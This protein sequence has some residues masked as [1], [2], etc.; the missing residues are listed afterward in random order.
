MPRKIRKCYY[1]KCKHGGQINIETDEYVQD[2]NLYH[3]DCYQEMKNLQLIRNLWIE[4]ISNTVSYSQLNKVLNSYLDRG[5]SSD[6]LL[7][8]LQYVIANHMT[9]RYPGGLQYY[10]DREEIKKQY[11]K[12]L[13]Q[14]LKQAPYNTAVQ[15][16][17]PKFAVKT[18]KEGFGS[19]IGD[20]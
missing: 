12:T 4:R 13:K 18:K 19:I 14:K 9:L 3:T 15:S 10:I 1:G 6:Y 2:K 7:F 16:N 8:T 11:Q 20:S 5:I 17:I